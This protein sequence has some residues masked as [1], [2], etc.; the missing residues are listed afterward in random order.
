MSVLTIA[1]KSI[2]QRLLA[3]SLTGL[4]V[5]LGVMMMVGVL[6]AYSVIGEAFQQRTIGY[7]LVVGRQ[8]SDIQLV[9][10]TV[11]RIG[12]PPANLPYRY[13]LELKNHKLVKQAVPIAMGDTT[14]EGGFP[15]VGTTQEYFEVEY[16]PG[17][18]FLVKGT[19]FES[20][21]DA[22]IGSR[23]AIENNWKIDD[24]DTPEDEASTFQL[25][26]GGADSGGHIHDEKFRVVGILKETGTANDRTVFIYL[27][28]FYA[29]AGHETP[30]EEAERREREFFGENVPD[31]EDPDPVVGASLSQKEVTAIL[32]N[33]KGGVAAPMLQGLLK[34]GH[35]AQAVNPIQVMR[36]LMELLVG[37]VKNA[38]LFMTGL[39]IVV[40]GISIFVSIYNSMSDRKK[41]IAIMRALGAQRRTVFAIILNESILLCFCG[42]LLGGLAGHA[43]IFIAAPY[44]E[45]ST[46]MIMNPWAFHPLEYVLL[47]AMVILASLVGFIPGMTAYKTDVARTLAD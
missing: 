3:S 30:P 33:T 7:E 16:A 12:N 6:V 20:G 14:K 35:R 43:M 47:P 17:Q 29:I 10:S 5:A 9:L 1:L 34:K 40:S 18:K 4:S 32:V 41:E 38:L 44:V 13:Y 39:V 24:P 2:R 45:Q 36:D 28:G 31:I 8:G 26:H 37:K 42:G 23:V 11:Y 19:G 15:L 22:I 46:G 21:L 27:G 25:I